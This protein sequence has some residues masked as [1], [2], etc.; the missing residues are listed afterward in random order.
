[1]FAYH[2]AKR[3]LVATSGKGAS[4]WGAFSRELLRQNGH[5]RAIQHVPIDMSAAYTKNISDNAENTWVVY[6]KFHVIHNVVEA[7]HQVRKAES[8]AD[9]GRRDRPVG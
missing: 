6:D 8:R 9:T 7:C 1:V 3:L 5:P 4:V 2:V